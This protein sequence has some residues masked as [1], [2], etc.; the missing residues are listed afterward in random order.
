MPIEFLDEEPK[1]IEF[2]D[3]PVSPTWGQMGESAI[4][5]FESGTSFGLSDELR[6]LGA[7]IGG[8]IRPDRTFEESYG[9]RLGELRGEIEQAKKQAPTAYTTGEIGGMVLAPSVAT[10]T[11]VAQGVGNVMAKGFVPSAI[12]S[13]G[14]GAASGGLYGYGTGETPEEKRAQAMQYGTFGGLGGVAGSA[15]MPLASRAMRLF[16]KKPP[17][18]PKTRDIIPAEEALKRQTGE[19]MDLST[20]AATQ[21]APLQAVEKAALKGGLGDEAQQLAIRAQEAEQRQLRGL[22]EPMAKGGEEAL[23]EAGK[24]VKSA[25][26]SIKAQVDKAYKDARIIQGVYINQSPIDEVFKPQVNAILRNGGFDVTDFTDKGQKIIKQIQ[27]SGFYGGKKVTAQNLEKMEFWRTRATNAANDA[28]STGHKS[29]GAALKSIVEAYDDFMGKMPAHALMSG[30]EKA[31]EAINN[32]RY[33][34]RKQGVLF[35]RNKIVKNLVQDNEL[36]NEEIANIVLTGSKASEKINKGAG[37]VIKNMK[38]TIPEEKQGDFINALKKGTMA[39]VLKKSEGSTLVSGE[40]ILMPNKLEK[41][42]GSILQNKTFLNEVFSEPEITALTALKNDLSKINSVQ[43]GADNY[44][45]TAYTLMR[46][47]NKVPL[48]SSLGKLAEWE[49]QRVASKDAKRVFSPII[50]EALDELRGQAKYYGA[51]SGGGIAS[52]GVNE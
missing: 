28:Y 50:G 20:G 14:L 7:G 4:K 3:E 34:R 49:G 38:K 22:L 15:I 13:A 36:T 35:E 32:A 18:P 1:R 2:L 16:G 23:E 19:I 37:A 11:R 33:L 26:K 43:A 10:P 42:I 8:A 47:F 31:I 44:S 5:G 45:N 41:E 40:N 30:D 29:E 6:A 17:T 48:A 12:T 27:D 25:Y 51:V 21:Q 52:V 24:S 39:R 46:F 9:R